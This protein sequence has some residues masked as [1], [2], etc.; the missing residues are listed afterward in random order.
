MTRPP[1]TAPAYLSSPEHR[2]KIE[3]EKKLAKETRRRKKL[4]ARAAKLAKWFA[5]LPDK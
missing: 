2:R 5:S 1:S 3:D 4:E